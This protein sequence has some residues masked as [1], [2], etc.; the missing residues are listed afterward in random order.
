MYETNLMNT[1]KIPSIGMLP[2][3]AL[4]IVQACGGALLNTD[5]R[6][7]VCDKVW[8]PSPARYG[9]RICGNTNKLIVQRKGVTAFG[10]NIDMPMHETNV[11]AT[12]TG[13]VHIEYADAHICILDKDWADLS[14][15]RRTV[16]YSSLATMSKH[17][18]A[19]DIVKF[20]DTSGLYGEMTLSQH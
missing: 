8:F 11:I 14:R 6:T 19:S 4:V 13:S 9:W 17:L 2:V 20:T 1:E 7:I 15:Y 3:T 18:T 16:Y 10:Q 12:A 5:V